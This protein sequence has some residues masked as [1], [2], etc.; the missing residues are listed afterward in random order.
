[1][2]EDISQVWNRHIYAHRFQEDPGTRMRVK[3]GGLPW[4]NRTRFIW[5]HVDCWEQA[6]GA[7]GHGCSF[8]NEA[9]AAVCVSLADDLLDRASSVNV[10]LHGMYDAQVSVLKRYARVIITLVHFLVQALPATG[11]FVC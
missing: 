2:H 6:H 1:M 4:Q 8:S 3:I 5:C 7:T 11:S 9:E 10:A